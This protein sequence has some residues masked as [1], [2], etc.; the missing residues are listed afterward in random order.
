MWDAYYSQLLFPVGWYFKYATGKYERRYAS[1]TEQC[2][3][4]ELIIC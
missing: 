2:T 4:K 1:Y 3:F